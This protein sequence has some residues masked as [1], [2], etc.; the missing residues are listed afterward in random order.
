MSLEKN[1]YKI[2]PLLN[3][4]ALNIAVPYVVAKLKNNEESPALL[5]IR[6]FFK[7]IIN[8]QISQVL[9]NFIPT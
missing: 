6:N 9:N 3:N 7:P 8:F 1:E 4:C 5:K 2:S